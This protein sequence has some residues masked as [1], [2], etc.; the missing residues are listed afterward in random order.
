M[1]RAWKSW[2]RAVK[3]AKS[4]DIHSFAD[5][6]GVADMRRRRA[7]EWQC[8]ASTIMQWWLHR[9]L[10]CFWVFVRCRNV[11]GVVVVK[12]TTFN[13]LRHQQDTDER[14]RGYPGN[15][16]ADHPGLSCGVE[17]KLGNHWGKRAADD[18]AESIADR[19]A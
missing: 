14:D 4:V 16:E 2:E 11:P 3:E 13:G 9:S 8:T 6:F 17:D 19:N 15:I 12:I 18:R 5:L 7:L 10:D 1:F